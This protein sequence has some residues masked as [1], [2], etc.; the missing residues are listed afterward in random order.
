MLTGLPASTLRYYETIG[1]IT[2]ISRGATSRHRSYSEEDLNLLTGVA[3]L[4]ATGLSLE[5]MK[6]YVANNAL[7]PAKAAD[8]VELLTAHRERL[9]VEAERIA[10]RRRYLGIKIDYWRAVGAGDD[11][12]AEALVAEGLSLVKQL[13]ATKRPD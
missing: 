6:H 10:L 3:C 7:G 12:R 4:N 1:V 2:P 13:K 9:A 5:D 8:Q 11:A